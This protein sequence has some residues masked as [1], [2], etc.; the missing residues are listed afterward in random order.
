[1]KLFDIFESFE[2]EKS[3]EDALKKTG[4]WGKAA[5]GCIFFAK[6]TG[7]FLLSH[8][9]LVVEQPGTWGG[10]GGAID[11]GENPEEAA[12]REAYEESGHTDSL[13]IIPLFVFKKETFRYYNFLAVVNKEFKPKLNWESDGF[14]WTKINEWPSP[15]HFGLKALFSDKE[16][17]SIMK[18]LSDEYK[19]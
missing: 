4:F 8:R 17:Y 15:L 2:D 9:S 7:K 13:E 3:H 6:D 10:W 12:R 1:M 16:S 11:L 19:L 5:A 14:I 18:N